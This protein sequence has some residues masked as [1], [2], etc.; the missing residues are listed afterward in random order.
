MRQVVLNFARSRNYALGQ[1]RLIVSLKRTGFVGRVGMWN[2]EKD[3]QAPP[4]EQEP[5]GFKPYAWKKAVESRCDLGV[6]VDASVYAVEGIEPVF[7]HIEEHGHIMEK[8]GHV[9]GDWCNDQ[10][11]AYFSLTREEALTIPMYGNA[12]FLGLDLRKP[13][14][15]SF[16]DQWRA[17]CDAGAF[18]GRWDDHRHDMACG[19]VIANRLGMALTDPKF[20]V[21]AAGY[22]GELGKDVVFHA[23]GM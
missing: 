22:D 4:H 17:A 5:Y 19:S 18:R 3:I 12:G 7:K 9:V 6:W 2:D 21:Y 14:S 23:Q 1:Q 16:L 10:A 15:L 13:T 11:L 8:S 20:L